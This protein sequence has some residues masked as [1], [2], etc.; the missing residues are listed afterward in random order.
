[1]VING[2]IPLEY[3]AQTWNGVMYQQAKACSELSILFQQNRD[4]QLFQTFVNSKDGDF[5]E[6]MCIFQLTLMNWVL[7]IMQLVSCKTIRI[8]RQ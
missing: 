8:A 5:G 4:N 2:V 1:M 7:L 6:R 3:I